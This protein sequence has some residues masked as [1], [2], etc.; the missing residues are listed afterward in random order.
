MGGSTRATNESKASIPSFRFHLNLVAN[1][2]A[3]PVL[4]SMGG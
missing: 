2:Q 3:L 4:R 1:I